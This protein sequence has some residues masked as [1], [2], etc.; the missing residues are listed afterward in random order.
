MMKDNV[1]N[2]HESRMTLQ[3]NV[4]FIIACVHFFNSS[5]KQ[6]SCLVA[7]VWTELFVV[8][9]RREEVRQISAKTW[10]QYSIAF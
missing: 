7:M 6:T 8:L 1:D 4:F 2:M 10:T 5:P 3:N 9:A